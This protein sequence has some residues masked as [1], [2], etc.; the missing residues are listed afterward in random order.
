[1]GNVF[2]LNYRAIMST[3]IIYIT[4]SNVY[5]GRVPYFNCSTEIKKKDERLAK[6]DVLDV[7]PNSNSI[8]N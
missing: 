1:M 2:N 6:P 8:S 5:L 4:S 3:D 7:E